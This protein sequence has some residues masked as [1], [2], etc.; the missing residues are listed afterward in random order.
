MA[1]YCLI[2][3][4]TLFR[5]KHQEPY[6]GITSS[7]CQAPNRAESYTVLIRAVDFIHKWF[8]HSNFLLS[9]NKQETSHMV[10]MVLGLVTLFW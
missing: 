5:N 10:D 7:H 2:I 3:D 8:V 1:I 4:F 9:K 6:Q